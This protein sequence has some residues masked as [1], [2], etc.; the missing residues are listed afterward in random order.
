MILKRPVTIARRGSILGEFSSSDLP[1]LLER[2]EIETTDN[3]FIEETNSWQSVEDHVRATAAPKAK[4][5]LDMDT[6]PYEAYNSPTMLLGTGGLVGMGVVLLLVMALLVAAGAWVYNLQKQLDA[7]AARIT[8]LQNELFNRPTT[9][10]EANTKP[11]IPTERT[12]MVG[13]ATMLDQN[14]GKQL[15]TGFYVDLYK[16]E[17]IRAYLLSRSLEIAA[18]KQSNDPEI[19]TRLLRDLPVPARKTATDAFGFYEFELPAEGRYV[20]YSSMTIDG[21]SGPEVLLWFLSFAT[22]DPL[23]LPVDINEDNRVDRMEPEFML[24]LGRPNTTTPR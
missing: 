22:D 17:T 18:Y 3:C 8:E 5:A 15:L 20:V 16:E 10:D 4:A 21:P 23:N 12:K 9:G 6:D 24:K 1:L 7:S 11:K 13:Q 2:G 19:L 14:G